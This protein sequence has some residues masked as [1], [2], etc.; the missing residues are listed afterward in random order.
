[1][2]FTVGRDRGGI[3]ASR[4]MEALSKYKYT[5]TNGQTQTHKY[6]CSNTNTQGMG[7]YSVGIS[8]L[9]D[10]WQHSQSRH[11]PQ[12]NRYPTPINFNPFFTFSFYTSYMFKIGQTRIFK[13]SKKSM[14]PTVPSKTYCPPVCE[15]YTIG[16][17]KC[18]LYTSA[19]W[20]P[21]FSEL[22][23]YIS[24]Y[25]IFASWQGGALELR[26]TPTD[27]LCHSSRHCYH[28]INDNWPT[29]CIESKYIYKYE[30]K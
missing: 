14:R 12:S 23:F 17:T 16:N 29:I 24:L 8:L 3:L 10:G 11:T 25:C 26:V 5:N 9:E 18:I 7:R 27:R 13:E 2:P 4:W 19:S 6:R 30:Y 20:K 22:C 21:Y 15:L 1:M 28:L